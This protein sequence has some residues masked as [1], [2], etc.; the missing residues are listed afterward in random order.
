L[1][2]GRSREKRQKNG[3]KHDYNLILFFS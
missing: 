1:H 3:R 2:G